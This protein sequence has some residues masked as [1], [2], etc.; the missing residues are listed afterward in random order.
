MTIAL[1]I[2]RFQP[3]HSGHLW[4]VKE[5]LKKS[6][7]VIIGIG[8]SQHEKTATNPFSAKERKEMILDTLQSEKI[9]NFAIFNIPDI[10]TDD[11]WV[12]HI[13]RIIPNFDVIYSGSPLSKKLFTEKGYVVETLPRYNNISASEIRLKIQKNM[14]WKSMVP[15]QVSEVLDHIGAKERIIK[16]SS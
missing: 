2:G 6:N 13:K 10:H 14:D 1:F 11:E 12:E 15:K 16:C 9:K 7:K 3:F 4:A 5:I 8:S